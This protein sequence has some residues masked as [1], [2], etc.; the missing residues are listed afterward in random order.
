TP[1]SLVSNFQKELGKVRL[2]NN[3]PDTGISI[4]LES[5]DKFI[6]QPSGSCRNSILILDEVHN[7]NAEAGI[8]FR[9]M[10]ECSKLAHK[11]ILLSATPV[12]NI[13]SE[14]VN[15]ISLLT[16]I[17]VSRHSLEKILEMKDSREKTE[18]F[19]QLFKCKISFFKNEDLSNYPSVNEHVVRL[20]MPRDYYNEYYKIQEDLKGVELPEMFR[21]AKDL[22]VFLNGVRRAVNKTVVM[23]PKV[24][25]VI[26]KI[27]KNPKM[28]ILIYSAWLD[29]GLNIIK[30]YL[31]ANGIPYSE[32]SGNLSKKDKDLSVSNYNTGKTKIM[33]VSAAGSEGLN[34]KE[35]RIVVI[36]EPHWNNARIRQIIG[37][38]VRYKSHAR[39]PRREKNVTV[40][41]LILEK[42]RGV[43]DDGIP[44]GDT[45]LY[46]LSKRKEDIISQ[47]Y[48]RLNKVFIENDRSCD[49][50]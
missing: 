46:E 23:S 35:T 44:S 2:S 20:N 34:L 27:N 24:V 19:N 28:K 17:R 15:Q 4:V 12:K 33:L 6:K 32:V 9:K 10:F 42:P 22:T 26:N 21:K 16:G 41:H 5:Y 48:K 14:I 18:L 43:V 40:Y 49:T 3:N 13:P 25:W 38:A 8:K 7:L 31:G 36:L 39:L 29:A 47:F 45:I 30:E 1:A 11:V 50:G 37:R